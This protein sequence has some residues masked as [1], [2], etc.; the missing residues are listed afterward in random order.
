M[1]VTGPAV[2]GT[3]DLA[4]VHATSRRAPVLVTL[5]LICGGL[6]GQ[7]VELLRAA[8]VL[9][10]ALDKGKSVKPS[11]PWIKTRQTRPAR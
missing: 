7:L 1:T 4:R 5:R 9:Q 11:N 10:P 3:G 6:W 2:V 8:T